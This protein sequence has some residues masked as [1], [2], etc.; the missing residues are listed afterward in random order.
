MTTAFTN[1]MTG[2][3]DYAGMFPPADL[4]VAEAVKKYAGYLAG[5]NGWMLGRCIIPIT[6][7]P[8]VVDRP[9]FRFSVIVSPETVQEE[10]NQLNRFKGCVEMV[11][12]RVA[13]ESASP[14]R[15]RE[16][17]RLLRTN[18]S[19]IGLQD[20]QLFVEAE[21]VAAAALAIVAVNTSTS[22]K[23]TSTH[24]GYK[25]RCGGLK[26]PSTPSPLKVAEA[27][28]TCCNHDIP[29]K[30]T[31][32]MHHPL[33][34]HSPET[35]N[36]QY[37]FINIVA[38][39]LLA[40]SEKISPNEVVECVCDKTIDDFHFARDHFSW[41]NKVISAGEIERLRRSSVVSFGS[42]SFSEPIEGLIAFGLP[43][44]SGV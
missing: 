16:R 13:E 12:T 26:A 36:L 41:R 11:E 40:W 2:L 31:A 14:S 37:G 38:A 7:V 20:A 4:D 22:R 24:V 10:L 28:S 21:N 27:I 6:Q 1:F 25:L 3:I 43:N 35:G 18:L 32:G 33:S 19:A 34:S 5:N 29:I 42:C 23:E 44:N 15:C 30:F 8:H 39:A 17:I 9:G